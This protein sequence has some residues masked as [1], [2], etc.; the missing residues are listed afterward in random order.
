MYFTE[1]DIDFKK[2]SSQ[3]FEELCFDLLLKMRFYNLIWRKGGP[4]NGRDIEASFLVVNPLTGYYEEKWFIECKNYSGGIPVTELDSK[5]SWADAEKP[6]HLLIIASPYISNSSRTWIDKRKEIVPYRVHLLE[7]INLKK[8]LLNN[9]DIVTKY[10]LS[11]AEKLLK[12]TING[13]VSLDIL[14][15]GKILHYIRNSL[16]IS[17]LSPW[18]VSFLW[19]SYMFSKGLYITKL[20]YDFESLFDTVCSC[21][22]C[23]EVIT[24][25]DI[26]TVT[27][28]GFGEV[29]QFKQNTYCLNSKVV[30]LIDDYKYPAL[31]SLV[32]NE[33]TGKGVEV[34]TVQNNTIN[35]RILYT[36]NNVNQIYNKMSELLFGV[37]RQD[38]Q[39]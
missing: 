39:Q 25:E 10:F 14:P 3:K 15:D 17:K 28:L 26:C 16:N 24:K 5:F 9:E 32:F 19:N 38:N 30:I 34:L 1:D 7:G 29:Y 12:H 23:S 31:Y 36:E 13:W 20:E 33:E 2:I 27:Q 35:T 6:N 18:E 21:S 22:N 4:D 8:M 37:W 11:K